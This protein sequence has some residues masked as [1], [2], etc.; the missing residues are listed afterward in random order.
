[1]GSV[2]NTD[3]IVSLPDNQN[4][5]SC[6][7]LPA[8]TDR[9][10][11]TE[12]HVSDLRKALKELDEG[13]ILLVP[14]DDGYEDSLRR[15]S[16][17]A[18]KRAGAVLLLKTPSAIAKALRYASEHTIDLAVRGGGH[19]TAGASST[20]GGLVIDL[21]SMRS[22]TV[23]STA[24]TLAVQ[25]GAQ[26]S[27]VDDAA[28]EH[29]LATVGGTVADTGVGGLTLGGGYGWLSGTHGLVIDNLISCE[30]VLA[31]GEVVRASKDE[32]ADLFWALRGGGQNFGVV[33]E[34]ILQAWKQDNV[35]AGVML[36]PTEK[37]ADILDVLNEIILEMR[38]R[39]ACV[40]G[41]SRPPPAGGQV[42]I[43]IAV[44][45]D[46]TEEEGR[47]R[48]QRLLDLGPI[49]NTATSVPYNSVNR[50]LH[51][52]Q[53]RRVSMKGAS[54]TLPLRFDFVKSTMDA[55]AQFTS[56]VPHSQES[57]LLYEIFEPGKICEVANHEM[58][59]ANRG[60]RMNAMVG[61]MWTSPEHDA[62]SRA[63]AREVADMFK[64]ELSRSKGSDGK[65]EGLGVYGNY[66]QYDEKSRDVFGG[67]Y[68]R[69]QELKAR[70]DA[71]NMF[72]KLF[73]VAPAV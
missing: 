3:T 41:F 69:L 70:Y 19:S 40:L 11:V 13:S 65:G 21:S 67:N 44:F 27:D 15:W 16:R 60:R 57:L 32:N 35:W 8:T 20:S 71:G 37:L 33:T 34:F 31:S 38:G 4:A 49:M 39:G 59:F 62:R 18:E 68:A 56:E 7:S 14:G 42:L 52:P 25:G 12:Q 63:W 54:F 64:A 51:V 73:S 17:A 47:A 66:D 1:M 43:I 46:G 9:K 48:F 22:V 50:M 55:Y 2:G 24:K 6:S 23:D 26:W 53:G 58:S 10:P 28:W 45:Y 72:N 29:G 61:P 30:I 36:F 5:W